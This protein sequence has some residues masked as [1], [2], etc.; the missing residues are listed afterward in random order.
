[1]KIDR[2]LGIMMILL[3]QEKVTAPQLAQR[4]EVSRRTINRDIEALCQAG[5]PLIT[6]QGYGGGI[7][8][9]ESYTI[10]KSLLTAEERQA[11]LAGLKGVD[12]VSPTSYLTILAEKLSGKNER[13]MADNSII[14][15]LASHYQA[16]LTQK[17]A[18]IKDA[19][20]KKRLISF[21][22]YNEK[23][24]SHRI[25]EPYHLLFRWSSWYV[26]GYCF[27]RED[28]RL[29]KLNRLWQMQKEEKTFVPRRFSLPNFDE[30][31]TQGTF[32][33]QALFE[34]SEKYRLIEEY[35]VGCFNENGDERLSFAWDFASYEH[36]RQWILSFGDRVE[37][38][39]P[40][41]LRTELRQTA[42]KLWQKYQET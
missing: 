42:Q 21:D 29:F 7:T 15:D 31:L 37:V 26:W 23:G 33:L 19:I 24:D 17:I 6:T 27:L 14:I 39:S 9:D 28:F 22:Y 25:I 32:H 35:G 8:L 11:L 38:L 4:F 2:L 12:S 34:Q 16:P 18:I 13:I 36:M 3:Q 40:Q 20:L 30:H 1:M 41:E 5:I 10:D